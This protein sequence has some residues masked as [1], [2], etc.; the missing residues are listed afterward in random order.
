MA[1]ISRDEHYR[2]RDSITELDGVPMQG[3][4]ARL[5]ATPGVLRW[6]GRPLDADGD[7]IR[8]HGWDGKPA[9]EIGDRA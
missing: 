7:S 6:A 1:D 4:I 3:L 8:A 9:N 2:F 5:A